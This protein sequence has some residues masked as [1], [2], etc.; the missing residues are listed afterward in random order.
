MSALSSLDRVDRR[1]LDE[2]QT[3]GRLPV[4]ELARRVHL[5]PTPC[6]ERIKRLEREGFIQGYN[7]RLDPKRLGFVVIAFVEVSIDRTTPDVLERFRLGVL[8]LVEVM[9]CH[10]VAGGFDYLLKVRAQSMDSFRRFLGERLFATPGLQHTHTYIALEELKSTYELPIK[11]GPAQE[12]EK[13]RR[14]RG[15]STA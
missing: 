9:E 5:S 1:L 13:R 6:L 11:P 2:L 14:R 7:A 10:M 15:K 12:T 3:D 4:A 8:D